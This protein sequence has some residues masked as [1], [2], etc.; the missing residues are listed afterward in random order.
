MW[1][2]GTINGF[3]FYAKRYE[4]GSVYGIN[5]G[6]ISKLEIR[7]NGKTLANYDRGWDLEPK[8]EALLATYEEI[9]AKYN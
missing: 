2:N 6:R 8:G 4:E 7:K 9:L 3:E 5:E 1:T